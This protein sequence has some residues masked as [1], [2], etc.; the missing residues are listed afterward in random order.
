[1]GDRKVDENGL[2]VKTLPE[3]RDDLANAVHTSSEFGAEANVGSDSPAGQLIDVHA[4]S[5]STQDELAQS[6][7][8][9]T[10]ADNAEGAHLDGV[11]ALCPGITREDATYSIVTL[12]LS[13]TPSTII[14]AGSRA[15]VPNGPQFAIDEDATIGGGGTVNAA[16]TCTEAGAFEA[17][18]TSIKEIVDPI[19]GWTGVTNA[20]DADQGQPVEADPDF[21]LRRE[22]SFH[23]AG[24][25]TDLA[26]RADLEQLPDVVHATV[27]SNR[28]GVTDSNGIPPG[29]FRP[30]I[31]PTTGV[32]EEQVVNTIFDHMVSGAYPDGDEEF[33]VTDEQGYEQPVRFSYATELEV[34]LEAQITTKLGYPT[35]GNDLVKAA[36]LAYGNT[37]RPGDDI[38][39]DHFEG[40]V[41]FSDDK[42]SGISAITV[43]AKIGSAPGSSDTAPIPLALTEIGT[44]DSTHISVVVS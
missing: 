15:R 9:S 27:I 16:A 25:G 41:L 18:A 21:R 12:T 44:F 43:L 34:Y 13:G 6:V 11:C 26:L 35:N 22:R 31:W 29:G 14:P 28:T 30:V 4:E 39:P 5:I 17:A 10:E 1:M 36:L 37:H 32:D 38:E 33:T 24:N 2:T 42:V 19:S 20:L 23:L 40:Y 3:I 7:Y 8:D